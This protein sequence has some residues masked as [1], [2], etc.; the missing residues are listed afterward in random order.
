MFRKHGFIQ[1]ILLIQVREINPF[2]SLD[3]SFNYFASDSEAE[4][5]KYLYDVGLNLVSSREALLHSSR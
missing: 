1:L 5:G 4:N 3:V 2:S